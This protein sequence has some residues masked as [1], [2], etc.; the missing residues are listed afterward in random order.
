VTAGFGA[1]ELIASWVAATP[2]DSSVRIEVR[3][4]QTPWKV[5]ADWAFDERTSM[6]DQHDEHGRVDADTFKAAHPQPG[7]QVRVTCSGG[8]SVE[9][10]YL[11]AS[12][13]QAGFEPARPAK[14]MGVVLEVPRYAQLLL[15]GGESLCSPTSTAMV[16][17][18]WG[19]AG[20]SPDHA[21]RHTFD[22]HYDGCG[23]WP[24]N[25][26][27]AGRFGVEAFVTRLRSLNEAELFIEAGIPLVVSASYRDD[28]V[29]GLRY[30]TEGHLMVLAGFTDDGDPVLNDPYSPSNDDVR[31]SVGRAEWETAW[32]RASGG[33]AYVIH[34][35]SVPLP[36]APAQ[37]NW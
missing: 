16:L 21:A 13:R 23:N 10:V 17:S 33:I 34:P 26:A 9:R 6:D 1:T 36:P 29:P 12:A 27:Y 31:K 32:Q 7:W 25:T 20:V 19:V 15:E 22:R 4:S 24:F 14:A 11:L 18:Y 28:E 35:A 30:E 5:I 8:A 37:A 2:G 3:G